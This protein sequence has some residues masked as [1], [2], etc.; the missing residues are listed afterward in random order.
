MALDWCQNFFSIFKIAWE[1]IDRFWCNIV[2]AVLWLTHEIFPN[3][4]TELGPLI[5]VKI[6]TFL[7]IF[8]N[9]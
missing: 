1:Q 2:Y 4:S 3:F 9:D 5:D 7:N 8:R 6:S